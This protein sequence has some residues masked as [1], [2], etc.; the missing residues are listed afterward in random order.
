MEYW[1]IY[2]ISFHQKKELKKERGK[3]YL[4][5]QYS[6]NVVRHVSKAL[7]VWDYVACV[8]RDLVHHTSLDLQH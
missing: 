7:F 8:S 1:K 2:V 4:L 6:E 3:I 5:D